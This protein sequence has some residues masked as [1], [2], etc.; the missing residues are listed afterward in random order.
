[1]TNQTNAPQQAEQDPLSDDYVNA[2]IGQ[3]GYDSPET[4]IAR[5]WQ[6]IGLNGGENCVTLLMCEAHKALSKLRAEGVQA[7][8]PIGFVDPLYVAGRQ[9]GM[10]WNAKI[11]D[12]PTEEATSPLYAALASAPV[13]DEFE[14]EALRR[15]ERLREAAAT[16]LNAYRARYG[17]IYGQIKKHAPLQDEVLGLAFAAREAP[18]ADNA[19]PQ[20]S[21]AVRDARS[22]LEAWQAV[23]DR[24]VDQYGGVVAGVDFAALGR[25]NRAALAAQ[26]GAQKHPRTDGGGRE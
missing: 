9:R 15:D 11:Y 10:K 8:E 20:A 12:A 26:P 16:F 3:H 14:R 21:E 19:A 25:A 1:M 23:C 22:V 2:V 17:G 18:P 7:G 4:V 24:I 13:A 5:L 6:W